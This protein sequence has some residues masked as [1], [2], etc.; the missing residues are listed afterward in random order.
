M[1]FGLKSFYSSFSDATWHLSLFN[2]SIWLEYIMYS[3][4]LSWNQTRTSIRMGSESLVIS[5]LFL[6][7]L[8]AMFFNQS[9]LLEI[10]C[11]VP[12]KEHFYQ[13]ILEADKKNFKVMVFFYLSD[14]ASTKDMY[15]IYIFEVFSNQTSGF[16]EE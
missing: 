14:V 4:K 13:I 3:A 11:R 12:L 2:Q 6:C 7:R 8:A 16:R 9:I 15:I 5:P 10:V 1:L